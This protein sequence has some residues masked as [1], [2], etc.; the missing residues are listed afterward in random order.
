MEQQ[1]RVFSFLEQMGCGALGMF[2]L[3]LVAF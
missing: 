3:I 2:L 1:N